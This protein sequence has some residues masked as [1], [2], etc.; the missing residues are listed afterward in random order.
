[1]SD[2]Y[3]VIHTYLFAL[4]GGFLGLHHLYL[5]RMQHAFLW[6]TTFGGGGWAF[7]YEFFFVI[8][9]YVREANRDEQ[10]IKE[11][12]LKM[13]RT[14]SPAW[15]IRRLCGKRMKKKNAKINDYNSI[16]PIKV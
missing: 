12:R 10:F 6:F 13:T 15:E 4:F 16:I 8:K 9:Q 7:F 3:S 11:Y 14:K 1:M 5:G 2:N